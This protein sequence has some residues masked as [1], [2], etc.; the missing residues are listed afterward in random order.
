MLKYTAWGYKATTAIYIYLYKCKIFLVEWT[1]LLYSVTI[2]ISTENRGGDMSDILTFVKEEL[3][4]QKSLLRRSQKILARAPEGTLRYRPR[5]NGDAFYQ[6]RFSSGIVKETNITEN[7]AAIDDLIQ[8]RISRETIPAAQKNIKILEQLLASYQLNAFIDIIKTLPDGYRKAVLAVAKDRT[9]EKETGKPIQHHYDPKKH[10][11]ETVCGLKV[12]SKSEVIITNSLTHYNIPFDYEL[13][14]D[15][16]NPG[17]YPFQ[18]DFTFELPDGSLKLWEHLGL[19]KKLDYCEHNAYKLNRYQLNGFLIGRNLI[20]TQDDNKG[21]CSSS[22]I[23]KMIHEH[24]LPY[25]K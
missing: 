24:L 13:D 17:K 9:L 6:A 12:R 5:K 18:P 8:K 1:E 3:E 15:E 16:E 7:K 22:F 25:Y 23:E 2:V 21:D 11:H 20:I 14:F 4:I 19:L 10:I